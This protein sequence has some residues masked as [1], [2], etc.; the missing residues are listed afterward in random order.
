MADDI[1]NKLNNMAELY[2]QA[3]NKFKTNPEMAN[4]VAMHNQSLAWN[5]WISGNTADR[6]TMSAD[7]LNSALQYAD[8]GGIHPS[9][10]KNL[11]TALATKQG[12]EAVSGQP[13]QQNQTINALTL[14][15]VAGNKALPIQPD[16]PNI[17]TTT[18]EGIPEGPVDE[19]Y[20][21]RKRK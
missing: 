11:R 6:N 19:S 2:S 10:I 9:N 14:N 18:T 3:Y 16:S 15:R 20:I 1:K 4:P 12:E 5:K 17:T 8:Q 13:P 21:N 7:E